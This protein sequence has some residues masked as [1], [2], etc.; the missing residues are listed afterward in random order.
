MWLS[1]PT[2]ALLLASL[3]GPVDALWPRPQETQRGK[4]FVR[5]S[6]DF[7]VVLTGSALRESVVYLGDVSFAYLVT[8]DSYS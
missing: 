5:L 8:R 7:D 2:L 1:S 6:K 3:L 4:D